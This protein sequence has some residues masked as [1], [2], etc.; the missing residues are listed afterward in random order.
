VAQRGR[1]AW[2]GSLPRGSPGQQVVALTWEEAVRMQQQEQE[3]VAEWWGDAA[4]SE[5]KPRG[6]APVAAAQGVARPLKINL[7]LLLVC[8][9]S[10]C[11]G[12]CCLSA[13]SSKLCCGTHFVTLTFMRWGWPVCARGSK[14]QRIPRCKPCSA[15][16]AARARQRAAARGA[17]QY[18]ARLA[19]R[20]AYQ[21]GS[22]PRKLARQREAEALLRRCLA[23]DPTDGRGYVGLGKLL[24]QQQRCEEARR[25]YDE[26][27]MATGAHALRAAPR[28]AG[29]PAGELRGSALG[30]QGRPAA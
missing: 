3:Q 13:A 5:P 2:A 1:P 19:R 20:A 30:A 9:W 11:A 29:S 23:L 6:A 22:P 15:R 25:L 21:A 18:R 17:A 26:G 27:T 14:R 10:L 16:H 24:L 7:D 4:E 12:R 8:C 28:G